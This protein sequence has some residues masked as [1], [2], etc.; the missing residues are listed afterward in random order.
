MM[1]KNDVIEVPSTSPS[2]L[3]LQLKTQRRTVDFDTYDIHMQQLISMLGSGQIY[4]SPAYQRKF[5]W[6]P[7]QCS[8]FI[9]SI[10][11]GIPIPSIF[12]ATNADSTWE[13]V[14]GV[15]RLSTI[16]KFAGD[17]SL[18]KKLGLNGRLV[19][20]DLEKLSHFNGLSIDDLPQGLQLHFW[21]RPAKVIA[22]N[23]KSDAIVRYDLFERL[24]T[25]GVVL[26]AQEIRDCV[27]RGEFADKIDNWSRTPHFQAAVKLTPRQQRDATAEECVLRFFAFLNRYKTFDHSVTDFL[28]GYMAS[29]SKTFDYVGGEAIFSKT[30][31]E[32]ARVFPG[33]IRRPDRKSTTPLIL[34]EGIA[35]G[36]ALALQSIPKLKVVDLKEWTGSKELRDFT[37]G[38]TNSRAAVRGRIEFCRDR[39]LGKPYVP[40]PST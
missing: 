28:N 20:S 37:T 5:R 6:L 8:Q 27:F 7:K 36:A 25:G 15:Q 3:E 34:F 12:M 24:N 26:S 14:D 1:P 10:M 17:E 16:I 22:L 40:K 35:V 21:T 38:A 2:G 31:K 4:V 30:F 9:E 19:L 23:D 39:F 32:I 13:V 33:G 11:L 18:R 29:A